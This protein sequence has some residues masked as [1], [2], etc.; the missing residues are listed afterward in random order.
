MRRLIMNR[1]ILSPVILGVLVFA[2][3]LPLA[4]QPDDFQ[5]LSITEDGKYFKCRYDVT[6]W[7]SGED[8]IYL[9]FYYYPWSGEDSIDYS[10]AYKL[11]EVNGK[12][13]GVNLVEREAETVVDKSG[14]ITAQV[15]SDNIDDLVQFPNLIAVSVVGATEED[16]AKLSNYDNLR[17]I[18]LAYTKIT[19]DGLAGLAELPEL[20]V[21]NLSYTKVSDEGLQ[22]LSELENLRSINLESTEI[23]NDGLAYLEGLDELRHLN[24]F[25]TPAGKMEALVMRGQPYK[26]GDAGTFSLSRMD[27]LTE[28]NLHGSD[29]TDDGID[30]LVSMTNLR[31]LDLS[32]TKITDASIQEL[33]K[34]NNLRYLDIKGTEITTAGLKRLRNA[35]PDCEIN[36]YSGSLTK[37]RRGLLKP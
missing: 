3:A 30:Q 2:L 32:A 9:S 27:K 10:I 36:F 21:L 5:M 31:F 19:N 33:S 26:V 28:L 23:T 24:L 1:K 22:Y 8:F 15:D 16:L 34:M 17:A 14:I 29:I 6:Y 11:L 37:D 18:D 13:V 7:E 12:I 35:L 20:R 25:R 4:A